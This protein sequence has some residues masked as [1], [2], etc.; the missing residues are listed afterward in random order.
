MRFSVPFLLVLLLAGPAALAQTAYVND[1]FEIVLRTGES[2]QHSIVRMLPTGTALEIL[3]ENTATGYTH[4]RTQDGRDGYVLSR[5]LS[6]QP[7]ARDRLARLQVRH[8]ALREAKAAVDGELAQLRK[9]L[10]AVESERDDLQAGAAQLSDELANIRRTAANVLRIDEQNQ[11]L[12]TRLAASESIINDLQVQN[13]A[14]AARSA[15]WW[16]ISGG[17][18]VLTG[19]LLGFLLPRLQWRRRSRWGDL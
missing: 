12:T 4:V 9:D 18:A 3:G 17:G 16:F 6:D 1:E 14:L 2:T 10:A 8:D 15:Q 19:A 5:F 7:A 11:A 13:D